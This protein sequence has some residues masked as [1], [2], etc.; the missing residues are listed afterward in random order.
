MRGKAL[1]GLMAC[2]LVL[3][4]VPLAYA[5]DGQRFALGISV[6]RTVPVLKFG[7]RYPA[8]QKYGLTFEYKLGSRATLEFEYHH[9]NMGLTTGVDY[10]T[11]AVVFYVL[12]DHI[13]VTG[14]SVTCSTYI[15]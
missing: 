11:V 14:Q 2:T 5:V 6:D 12:T 3:T 1:I 10:Y 7:E 15:P 4:C 13:S 9:A 8:S